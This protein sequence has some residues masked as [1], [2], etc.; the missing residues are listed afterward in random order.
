MIARITGTGNAAA[1]GSGNFVSYLRFPAVL[2]AGL[3]WRVNPPLTLSFAYEYEMWSYIK[4]VAR[5]YSDNPALT[6]VAVNTLNGK[7]VGNI[8]VGAQYR[9]NKAKR[10]PC[11]L[12]LLPN[13]G[14]TSESGTGSARLQY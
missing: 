8:R 14:T 3:A 12:F 13:S 10:V 4:Q 2:S 5:V 7:D 11:R 9:P 6:A 1:L